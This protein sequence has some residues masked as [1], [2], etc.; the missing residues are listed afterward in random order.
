MAFY[1]WPELEMRERRFMKRL[2]FTDGRNDLTL[3][4][5]FHSLAHVILLTH[6]Q[7]R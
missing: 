4:V 1:M 6:G 2:I 5:P 7:L 3:P